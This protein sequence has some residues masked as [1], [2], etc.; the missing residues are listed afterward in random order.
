MF[1]WLRRVNKLTLKVINVAIYFNIKIIVSTQ[2]RNDLPA[3]N[4]SPK[5]KTYKLFFFFAKKKE[6][7]IFYRGDQN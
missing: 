6:L 1:E 2:K 3:F 5:I 4:C 7:L